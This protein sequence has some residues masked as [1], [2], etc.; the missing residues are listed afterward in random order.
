MHAGDEFDGLIH[1][2]PA[3]K[4]RDIGDETCFAHQG[5]SIAEGLAS[6]NAERPLHKNSAREWPAAR[7]SCPAPLGPMRPTILPVS[8]VKLT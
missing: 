3:W 2:Q 4:D 5:G 1:P 6:E 8:T 7:W